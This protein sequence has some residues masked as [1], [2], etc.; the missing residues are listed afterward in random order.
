VSTTTDSLGWTPGIWNTITQAVKDETQSIKI[1]QKIVRTIPLTG[2]SNATDDVINQDDNI[3]TIPEGIS[4]AFI[5]TSVQFTLTK[6]QVQQ[7]QQLYTA[8][9]LARRA[10]NLISIAQDMIIFQGIDALQ[11][12]L[13]KLVTI[14]RRNNW[15]GLLAAD[16]ARQKPISV[17]RL[18][19]QPEQQGPRYGENIFGAVTRG[20]AD[21]QARVHYGPYALVLPTA[22]YADTYAPI[23][24]IIYADRIK[25]LV[26]RGFFGTS[27]LPDNLGILL[28]LGGDTMDLP[29]A[30]DATPEFL[31]INNQGGYNFRLFE[32]FS[33][34]LKIADAVR[35]LRF[36][37]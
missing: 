25:P 15:P 7:E 4:T 36:N 19:Q 13:G 33:F 6:T 18:P 9:T 20:I 26:E 30:D 31:S 37:Q 10:A 21:L 2:A 23:N 28:S 3:L 11:G 1:A 22:I 12:R 8:I 5:E 14:A 17:Q 34:R 16:P 29:V 24:D 32:R 27:A 35:L